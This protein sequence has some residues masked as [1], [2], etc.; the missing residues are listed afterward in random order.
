MLLTAPQ[1]Q[2]LL[3]LTL[4]HILY[5]TQ[6]QLQP[7][8][9]TQVQVISYRLYSSY[10]SYQLNTYTYPKACTQ[11]EGNLYHDNINHFKQLNIYTSTCS[12]KQYVQNRSNYTSKNHLLTLDFLILETQSIKTHFVIDT[13]AHHHTPKTHIW[14]TVD[15]RDTPTMSP[16]THSTKQPYILT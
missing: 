8:L 15:T 7:A 4:K 5:P 1:Q 9:N 10:R 11:I 13:K 2:Q 6:H 3:V 12:Q 16:V 14:Q